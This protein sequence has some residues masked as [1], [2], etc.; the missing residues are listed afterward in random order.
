[1][2]V[3]EETILTPILLSPM[4]NLLLLEQ[5]IELIN[6]KTGLAVRPSER[7]T[8]VKNIR[9]RTEQL[10]LA[11]VAQY[12][13]LLSRDGYTSQ[14]EWD[15]F[16]NLLAI[17]ESY[18][19]RDRGQMDLLRYRLLPQ[20]IA[21]ARAAGGDRPCLKIWSAGCST[22]EEAY[23]LAILLVE[24][25]PDWQKWQIQILG[26]DINP[27]A[28]AQARVGAYKKWSFRDVD[29]RIKREYFT[30]DR[31]LQTLRT[32][33]REL[34][35]FKLDNLSSI[36]QLL[37][38]QE[39]FKWDLILCRNVFIYLTKP[40]IHR[41]LERFYQVLKSEGC[42]MVSHSELDGYNLNEWLVKALPESIIYQKKRKLEIDS[43]QPL[44]NSRKRG[45]LQISSISLQPISVANSPVDAPMDVAASQDYEQAIARYR[46]RIQE[47]PK[48]FMALFSLAN[49]YANLGKLELSI[50][51]ATQCIS[52]NSL[53]TGPYYLLAQ[54]AEEKREIE[55]AK[56]YLK[57]IIYL[58]SSQINAYLDLG[59]LYAQQ[60]NKIQARKFWKIAL[61]LLSNTDDCTNNCMKAFIP[62]AGSNRELIQYVQKQLK[63]V[64]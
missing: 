20:L 50:K 3:A 48:D 41:A 46:R 57:R 60:K 35:D 25:I 56:L 8:L 63:K 61:E 64:K 7:N 16:I 21:Q 18:F 55:R 27:F 36:P 30:E 52:L 58:D 43:C 26:T 32:E 5:F 39:Q 62:F 13:Q 45:R 17:G 49:I 19:F 59:A 12:Y 42:L 23:S 22:G 10:R 4:I 14:R 29:A 33:I 24:L 40:A 9:H 51:Y 6:H 34:V 1:M 47:N 37:P 38:K 11:S 54:I 53:A 28:I 15:N 2:V 44:Q 31:G